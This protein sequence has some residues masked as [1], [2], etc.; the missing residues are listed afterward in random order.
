MDEVARQSLSQQ[1]QQVA[2]P[3]LSP[4]KP[5]P[6]RNCCCVTLRK[7]WSFQILVTLLIVVVVLM[8]AA[9]VWP[10]NFAFSRKSVTLVSEYARSNLMGKL[11]SNIQ[12]VFNDI[13][14][15]LHVLETSYLNYE[16]LGMD[17]NSIGF[18]DSLSLMSIIFET[19]IV[20][21]ADFGFVSDG[22]MLGLARSN[23]TYSGDGKGTLVF[24]APDGTTFLFNS[25]DFFIQTRPW[26]IIPLETNTTSWSPIFISRDVP[27]KFIITLSTPYYSFRTGKL[28]GILAVE[29]DLNFLSGFVKTIPIL[30]FTRVLILN[31]DGSLIAASKG[32]AYTIINSTTVI[33]NTNGT[34]PIV[35]ET[36]EE[37]IDRGFQNRTIVG[38]QA[39]SYNRGQGKRVVNLIRIVGPLGITW[40]GVFN[41][42]NVDILSGVY[43]ANK[44]NA[45]ICSVC[46]V[47]ST[48]IAIIVSSILFRPLRSVCHEMD[49]VADME[50]EHSYRIHAFYLFELSEIINSLERMKH[51][52][53]NFER[54]VPSEIVKAIVRSDEENSLGVVSRPIT[55]MFSDIKDFT[56]LSEIMDPNNLIQLL[57]DFFTNMSNIIVDNNGAVDKY[58][59][60]AIMCI[61]NAPNYVPD[62]EIS[63]VIAAVEMKHRLNMLNVTWIQRSLPAIQIRI[64]INTGICLVGN[65]GSQDRMNYTVLGDDVNIASRCES[66]NK[67]YDSDIMITESTYSALRGRFLCKWLA[68]VS[69]KGKTRPIHVYEVICSETIATDEQKRKCKLYNDLKY[70]ISIGDRVAAKNLCAQILQ[71]NDQDV[72]AKEIL[73]ILET[74]ESNG[75]LLSTDMVT[76]WLHES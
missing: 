2:L 10:S 64:G 53:R 26:Y 35:K 41:T 24:Y 58:I 37:I 22:T 75:R 28:L 29:V 8:T 72:T 45:I 60:D 66:L 65:V 76:I 56:C 57:S 1:Q 30:E 25:T 48:L 11:T 15:C 5:T 49:M 43:R 54:Y 73:D 34:D 50:F 18:L 17:I 59:G 61:F 71:E 62:H 12:L 21:A 68:Y 44:T 13:V 69:L 3:H 31:T 63:A 23:L 38:L 4:Q 33:A 74:T 14:Q 46:L 27:P 52:L 40:I 36:I 55:V 19:P 32:D 16:R 47:V 7:L 70:S 6:K 20:T 67:R 9:S 42:R 39:F 51:G